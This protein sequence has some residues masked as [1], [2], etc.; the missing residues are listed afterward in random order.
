MNNFTKRLLFGGIYVALVVV[1]TWFNPLLFTFVF[2]V[3]MLFCIYE[4]QKMQQVKSVFPYIT[5]L[6]IVGLIYTF[7]NHFFNAT[8]PLKYLIAL[9][10]LFL[11]LPFMV[12]LFQNKK[13]AISNLKTEYL[14]FF[15]LIIP[16][17]ILQ[18]IPLQTGGKYDHQI[19]LGIFILIWIN[20]TFAYLV[21]RKLGKHKLFERIS[22][23]K[24]IEGFIGGFIFSLIG[25]FILSKYFTNI[26]PIHWIVIAFIASTFGTIG[27]LIESL[28]KRRANI[29]DSSN[30]IPGHGGFLDRLDSVIFATPFI[31]IYLLLFK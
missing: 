7:N 28:F 29:K 24:T 9:V 21:G 14:T 30:L 11:Y 27:D 13:E 19:V 2:S 16:F 18:I 3:F 5:G 10:L 31:F 25:G 1:A 6:T 23:K 8:I 17:S 15:Y 22:P 12:A 4:F 26:Q 20:D